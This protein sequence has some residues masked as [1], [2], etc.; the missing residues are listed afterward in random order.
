VKKRGFSLIEL[1]VVIAIIA[2]LGAIALPVYRGKVA[3]SRSQE[4]GAALA[5]IKTRQE[6]YR[7]THFRYAASLSELPG[8]DSDILNVGDYFQITIDAATPT[9]FQASARDN[10]KPI[11]SKPAGSDVWIITD[12]SSKP[13][14]TSKGY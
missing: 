13:D 4:G 11:G 1:M 7:A 2:I 3:E 12:S 9:S 5:L 8:Y 6:A 14:H 10:Q